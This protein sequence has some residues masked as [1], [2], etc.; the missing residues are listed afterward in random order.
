LPLGRI[1][2]SLSVW[3]SE[4]ALREFTIAPLHREVMIEYRVRGYLR[5]IHWW[6]EYSTIGAGAAE[7]T[8]RLDA[9]EGR[10]VGEAR[11]PWARRDQRRLA[12]IEAIGARASR[13]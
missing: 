3:K 11:D 4:E 1:T 6:G 9:G 13:A 5:H 8:R 2:Y 10:R 7:A 12:E